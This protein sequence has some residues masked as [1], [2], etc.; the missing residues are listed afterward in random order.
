M[1]VR[2]FLR[3]GAAW[4]SRD[5]IRH[6][7]HALNH[8]IRR[9]EQSVFFPWELF[10]IFQRTKH[11]K[12]VKSVKEGEERANATVYSWAARLRIGLFGSKA[13]CAAMFTKERKMQDPAGEERFVISGMCTHLVTDKPCWYWL[14]C[15]LSWVPIPLIFP[16]KII[17]YLK[18]RRP[19]RSHTIVSLSLGCPQI[20]SD[21]TL[22]S[23]LGKFGSECPLDSLH[24]V[25]V[26]CIQ[27]VGTA[28]QSNIQWES[29]L[30]SP[31]WW[32]DPEWCR[33]DSHNLGSLKQ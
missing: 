23:T 5:S 30:A 2:I 1:T 24:Y 16:P 13:T 15:F 6:A 28:I 19:T 4:G 18:A 3:Y 22:W 12:N 26:H 25:T 14:Q 32:Y 33:I 27:L 9:N 21:S 17:E 29:I 11:F 20:L 10:S 7:K 31:F 8:G